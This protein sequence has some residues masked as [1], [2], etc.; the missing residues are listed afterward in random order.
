MDGKDLDIVKG[1]A[2]FRGKYFGSFRMELAFERLIGK[3]KLKPKPREPA[4]SFED[5]NDDDDDDACEVDDSSSSSS[6]SDENETESFPLDFSFPKD[7]L[8]FCL[9]NL[10]ATNSAKLSN[11]ELLEI[12]KILFDKIFDLKMYIK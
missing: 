11:N 3:F 1:N 10:L 6:S 7:K 8:S 5:D 12:A 2:G 4:V 9:I